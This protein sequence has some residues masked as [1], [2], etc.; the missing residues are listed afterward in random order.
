[1]TPRCRLLAEVR[2]SVVLFLVGL[3]LEVDLISQ[4]LSDL[5]LAEGE[6]GDGGRG[7]GEGGHSCWSETPRPDGLVSPAGDKDLDIT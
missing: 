2:H 7:G 3:R 1:M 6:D 4:L 5:H